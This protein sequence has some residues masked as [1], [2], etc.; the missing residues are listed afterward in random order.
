[1][2][3]WKVISVVVLV[4]LFLILAMYLLGTPDAQAQV[5]DEADC[6]FGCWFKYKL[7]FPIVQ[8]CLGPFCGQEH[9]GAP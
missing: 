5:L 8:Q 3:A 2:K 6:H 9:S 7:W 1:M 4:I